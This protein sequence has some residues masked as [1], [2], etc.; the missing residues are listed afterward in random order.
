MLP[1][2]WWK[3][4]KNLPLALD[5]FS[6]S[7]VG[8]NNSSSLGPSSLLH[9][10]SRPP[11]THLTLFIL[12]L[13]FPKELYTLFQPPAFTRFSPCLDASW[14]I[15]VDI[16][17]LSLDIT[18]LKKPNQP[19][20]TNSSGSSSLEPTVS[21]TFRHINPFLTA[22]FLT[23][24]L[25]LYCVHIFIKAFIQLCTA[26]PPL[27][28]GSLGTETVWFLCYKSSVFSSISPPCPSLPSCE[29]QEADLQ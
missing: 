3:P 5:T 13:Q 11:P 29:P 23:P 21:L 18:S 19:L 8:Q 14:L 12:H 10:I 28:A 7:L 16:A 15:S 20:R 9:F 6:K 27:Y 17:N 24:A 26:A 25:L 22:H 2:L 1:L 4:F